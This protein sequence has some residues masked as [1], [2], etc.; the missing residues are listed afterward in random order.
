VLL[1]SAGVGAT[2]LLAMLHALAAER[3]EREVWWL[4]G[5]RGGGER[6]FAAESRELLDA[7]PNAR[8]H[9][10]LSRPGPGDV[11]GR[12][13]QTAGRLSAALLAELDL[14]R[15]ADAY[16]CGPAPFM[17]EVSAALAAHGLAASRIRTEPFGPAPSITPGIG[18]A[19]PRRPHLPAGDPRDGPA[20]EFARSDLAVRWDPGD[21]SLLELAEACDVPVR[22]SCRTGVCHTCETAL[23]AGSVDYGPEPVEPPAEGTAL[24]CCARPRGDVVLDL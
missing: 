18:A 8:S 9:V 22:W 20:V 5:A 19:P 17:D 10:C 12:D 3:S 14:P 11:E 6:P 2:P 23:V 1:V 4:H 15:D 13:F 7:L 24:I 21:G 16:L